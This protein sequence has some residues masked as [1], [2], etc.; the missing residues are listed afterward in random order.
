[1]PSTGP[2]AVGGTLDQAPPP[3]LTTE[4]REAGLRDSDL[5]SLLLG[6]PFAFWGL[7]TAAGATPE[8]RHSWSS[9]IHFQTASVIL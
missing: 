6:P 1:M 9:G 2:W 8:D 4:A 3:N 7:L 5:P